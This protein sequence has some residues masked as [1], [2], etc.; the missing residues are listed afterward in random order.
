MSFP[1]NDAHYSQIILSSF[2]YLLFSKLFQ[3]NLRRPTCCG[4]GLLEIKCPYRYRDDHPLEVIDTN[5]YL[6]KVGGTTELKHTRVFHPIQGQMAICN[7]EYCDFVYWTTKGTYIEKIT[8]DPNIFI[9]IKPSLDH[10]FL[11]AVLP[12][13]LTHAIRDG[14][15]DK[16]NIPP[17][18]FCLCKEG[19]HGRM[20]A[21]DNPTCSAE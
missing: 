20:V 21:C 3:H 16:E 17:G 4:V 15:T 13:L 5:F 7:K 19:E 2:C 6:H 1:K 10:F 8:F 12:E 18:V 11:N 9:G 14:K